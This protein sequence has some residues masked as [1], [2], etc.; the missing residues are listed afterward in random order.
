[1]DFADFDLKRKLNDIKLNAIKNA[2]PRRIER[3]IDGYIQTMF[4]VDEVE[5]PWLDAPLKWRI[6]RLI[7]T[8]C[9]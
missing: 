8:L 5:V 6:W 2:I 4:L 1:M 9:R 3:W 7:R